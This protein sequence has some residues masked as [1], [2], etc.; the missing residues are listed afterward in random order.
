MSFIFKC[1]GLMME[2]ILCAFI[3]SVII[4]FLNKG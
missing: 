1:I 3:V 4:F 2:I